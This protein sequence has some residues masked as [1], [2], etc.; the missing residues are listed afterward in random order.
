MTFIYILVSIARKL[1]CVS[2]FSVI[3]HSAAL[4][5]CLFV[6]ACSLQMSILISCVD[7]LTDY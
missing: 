2:T 3:M 4:P 1:R 7:G 6:C 5:V